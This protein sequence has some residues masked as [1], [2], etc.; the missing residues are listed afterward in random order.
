MSVVALSL[1]GS[2][3]A[4]APLKSPI[5]YVRHRSMLVGAAL[6]ALIVLAAIFAPWLAPADPSA[7]DLSRRVHPPAW[8][9]GDLSNPLGTDPLGRDMLSRLL[10]GARVSL[11]VGLSA[12]AIQG[13][14]GATLGLAA[15]YF[16]G[17]V[18]M[19]IMRIADLQLSIP[20]LVLA[21]AVIAVLGSSLVNVIVILGFTG[22]PYFARLARSET[23]SVRERDFVLA[24][25]S[26][27]ASHPTIMRCHILPNVT[28]SLVVAATFA[29]P[30]MI[31]LE[32]SL[33]FLGVGV[34]P[35]V[36]TWGAMVAD[37]RDYLAPAWWI[38]T[39]PGLAI[40][41][42]VLGINLLGDGL[43]DA[44][45]PRTRELHG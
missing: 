22:W 30:L 4:L 15:G 37:G 19:L 44:L 5:E 26:I 6:V 38:A 36:P 20:P 33:S 16:K 29:V 42:V 25:R 28:T 41:F 35:S 43:R 32:A 13:S 2:K 27:G 1:R 7:Q 12:V 34:P 23:L 40:F 9:G 14:L 10:F 8:N 3:G 11:V 18:D 45:D 17:R 24:A 39:L 31:V 21:I